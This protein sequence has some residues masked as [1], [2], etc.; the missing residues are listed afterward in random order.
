MLVQE[1]V[2]SIYSQFYDQIDRRLKML[3]RPYTSTYDVTKGD[4]LLKQIFMID[5]DHK[6]ENVVWEYIDKVRAVKYWGNEKNI[7]IAKEKFQANAESETLAE[8]LYH[9]LMVNYSSTVQ[10]TIIMFVNKRSTCCWL[11]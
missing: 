6:S 4:E 1:C 7:L 8:H 9:L 2:A 3:P 5:L 11:S 10:R